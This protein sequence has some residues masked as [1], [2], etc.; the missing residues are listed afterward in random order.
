[1]VGY[2]SALGGSGV[3]SPIWEISA[4]RALW[5]LNFVDIA[6]VIVGVAAAFL[7]VCVA[8]SGPGVC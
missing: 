2:V 7:L 4:S 8:T 5:S 3:S 6:V 1:M